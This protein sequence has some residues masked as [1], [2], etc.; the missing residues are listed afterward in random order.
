MI[1][2]NLLL[3]ALWLLTFS[4]GFWTIVC[5]RDQRKSV[6]VRFTELMI[7]CMLLLMLIG[8]SRYRTPRCIVHPVQLL[9]PT[10]YQ[11]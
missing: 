2:S 5:D 11:P 8:W 10:V 3:I 4:W 7:V 9:Q 1:N 6:E